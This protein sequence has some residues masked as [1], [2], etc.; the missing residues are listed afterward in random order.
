MPASFDT[1][2]FAWN[3]GGLGAYLDPE[4]WAVQNE[5]KS[6]PMVELAAMCP[7]TA[8]L[9]RD[10][11]ARVPQRK[12]WGIQRRDGGWAEQNEG[13]WYESK[14]RLGT[15]RTWPG[16]RMRQEDVLRHLLGRT[17]AVGT[18]DKPSVRHL[19]G[20]GPDEA[21]GHD[22]VR[23]L[24]IDV[25]MN[26][27]WA[28]QDLDAVV[29]EL[30]REREIVRSA[31]LPF[32]AFRTGGRGHQLV[33][34]LPRPLHALTASLLSRAM[35][36]AL[37]AGAPR[38][39]QVDKDAF[40]GLLRLPGGP[41]A[42]GPTAL[43][44]DVDGG[45]LHSL[46]EQARRT[47]AAFNWPAGE[48][49]PNLVSTEECE[50]FEV[51]A[52][53]ALMAKG[54]DLADVVGVKEVEPFLAIISRSHVVERLLSVCRFIDGPVDPLIP[55]N[56]APAREA[57]GAS[58]RRPM[59]SL[60]VAWAQ[61]VLAMGVG[62]TEYHE[63]LTMA[64]HRGMLAAVI[65]HGKERAVGALLDHARRTPHVSSRSLRNREAMIAG[66]W[67]T[68]PFKEFVP[69]ARRESGG[70]PEVATDAASRVL[71]ELLRLR[72]TTKQ[73][74]E[75]TSRILQAVYTLVC[76]SPYGQI[77]ASLRSIAR[78]VALLFGEEPPHHTTV[79]RRLER[80]VEDDRR[81]IVLGLTRVPGLRGLGEPDMYMPGEF[82]RGSELWSVFL[83]KLDAFDE[84]H[85]YAVEC[86]QRREEEGGQEDCRR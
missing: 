10:L 66:Y 28:S 82:L 12:R 74:V 23:H 40:N 45:S 60:D 16:D 11:L 38:G 50:A 62:P 72:P 35:L 55:L 54:K 7:R 31:G 3:L 56:S 79:L 27:A 19:A 70:V 6:V 5:R 30:R 75:S 52:L 53:V 57:D 8:T 59:S 78:K 65:V 4:P 37:R 29:A 48:N 41:H 86:A 22:L 21:M 46:T 76:E 68:F 81:C 15:P 1:D 84:A 36:L 71:R 47:A 20:A 9:A 64:G 25:D 39:V 77:E 69:H 33:L 49:V 17:L 51:E 44:I 43:W 63:W 42:R 61:Q 14:N 85:G 26:D 18:T 73:D 80:V 34:P 83:E 13:D 67:R 32:S 2:L 24:R 58:A